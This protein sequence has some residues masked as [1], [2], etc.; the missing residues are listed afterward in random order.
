MSVSHIIDEIDPSVI[1]IVETHYDED[2]KKKRIEGYEPFYNNHTSDSG[3]ILIGVKDC[4]KH[5]SKEVHK[6]NEAGQSLW[7]TIDNNV[8]N[9][10]LGVIY[11][12]Q[13]KEAKKEKLEIMYKDIE[14]QVDIAINKGQKLLIV[15][16]FNCHVGKTIPNNKE[17]LSVGGRILLKLVKKKN[18]IILNS[19]EICKGMWTRV[20]GGKKSAIDFIITRREDL[21]DF[22]SMVIDEEREL[23]V[24]RTIVQNRQKKKVFSDHN[25]ILMRSNW[26]KTRE[27]VQQ[28]GYISSKGYMEFQRKLKERNVSQL[29]IGSD[30][31]NQYNQWSNMIE[32][33]AASV[34]KIKKKKGRKIRKWIKVKKDLRRSLKGKQSK[35]EVFLLKQRMKL[36]NQ[37]LQKTDYAKQ[38]KLIR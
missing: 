11:A 6:F 19:T 4:L 1:C 26:I 35:K 9:I 10:R 25:V 32:S 17:K 36:I 29:L 18:L 23:E 38:T 2:E 34:T 3:G 24:Y 27:V 15:G 16:D 14:N 31:Q 37:H 33:I 20:E 30:Y 7:V 5:I 12:P 22:Q 8:V 13:E 21:S 28:K